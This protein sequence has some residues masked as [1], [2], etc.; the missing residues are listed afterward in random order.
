MFL[1]DA[2]STGLPREDKGRTKRHTLRRTPGRKGGFE[3]SGAV[4]VGR[5]SRTVDHH[6][7]LGT[8]NI[9]NTTN[10][11]TTYNN[12]SDDS[13]TTSSNTADTPGA[14]NTAPL[15]RFVS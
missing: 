3:R 6:D 7:F 9:I 10:V 2:K 14:A 8:S 4:G 5:R 13:A 11:L 15:G 12:D 1:D